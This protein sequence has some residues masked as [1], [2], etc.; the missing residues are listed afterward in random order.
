[1]GP[2]VVMVRPHGPSF[3]ALNPLATSSTAMIAVHVATRA[4]GNPYAG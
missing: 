2:T 3:P 4:L 1:M